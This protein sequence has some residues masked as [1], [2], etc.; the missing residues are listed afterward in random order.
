MTPVNDTS[1]GLPATT[2]SI[3]RR[4]PGYEQH[5]IYREHPRRRQV[6]RF[7]AHRFLE[8]HG[9]RISS[10]M[11]RLAALFAENGEVL[12]AVGI[13]DAA[14]EALFLEHYLDAPVERAI[15]GR[16]DRFMLPPARESIV[17]IGNLASA[18]Q[19]ASRR[20]F[21]LLASYLADRGFTWAVFTGCS[22]LHRMFKTLGIETFALGRALQARLP[23]DQQTWGSYYEDSPMV[24]A[25][26]VGQG[27]HAFADDSAARAH[28]RLA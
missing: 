11:P 9:A 7:I 26:R 17:E 13:R 15:A 19:R 8:V 14:A 5:L 2:G 21:A 28:G 24:V 23:A 10:F 16:A 6:E 20:L 4:T 1:S 25:G 27:R 22:S 3:R 18:D 12:A